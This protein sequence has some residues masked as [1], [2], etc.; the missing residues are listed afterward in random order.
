MT[1]TSQKTPADYISPLCINE[2][3]GRMLYMP[4][5]VRKKREIL[6]VYG[7]HSTLERCWGIAEDLNQ[8]GAVTAPDLPGFGGMDSFYKVGKSATLDNLAD[9]LA[10]F[11]KLRYKRKRI[12]IIGFS[13]G[14]VVA[15]RMLQRYPDLASKVDLLISAA[16]F[17]HHDDFTFTKSRT[18]F[19]H[20][21]SSFFSRRLPAFVFR[22]IFLS[23][24]VLKIAY[25]K[26]KNAKEKFAGLSKQEHKSIMDFEIKLWHANDVRTHMATS[27]LFFTLDNCRQKV[28]LPVWHV[29]VDIDRYFDNHRVE[30][31]LNVIFDTCHVVKSQMK[32]HGPSVILDKETAKPF[33]PPEIRKLLAKRP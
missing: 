4:A 21:T 24:L 26:T 23:P 18:K 22:Y 12:T 25:S 8:Y 9:Y 29:A 20:L 6:F 16:G 14:F 13:F 28:K 2:L 11:V 3:C 33:T 7:H 27:A 31:H 19:Y 1:K 10:S 5:P 32:N 30:Q 15:T 17:A